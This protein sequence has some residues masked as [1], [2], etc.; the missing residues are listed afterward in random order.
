MTQFFSFDS[1]H[2]EYNGRPTLHNISFSLREGE[3]LGIIGESGSGKSTIIKSIIDI[4]GNN[5]RITGGKI[6]FNGENLLELSPQKMRK[7]CGP[8]IGMIFQD[9]RSALCPVRSIG[10]QIHD[11]FS[12]HTNT[13]RSES[14]RQAV[15]LLHKFGFK[16]GKRILNS[17]PFELSGG[18]IQR[19]GIAM[20][21]LLN[22][23]LILADEPT[24]A[25]D[26]SVQKQIL[27]EVQRLRDTYNTA[28]IFVS[29]N[30]GVIKTIAD[31][32]MVLKNGHI[33]E[34]GAT[35]DVFNNPQQDYTKELIA[36]AP[37]LR[38]N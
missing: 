30:I 22:P 37:V 11:T 13:S 21:M 6:W 34:Y 12:A 10:S 32:V 20:A 15:D 4:L 18:M 16:D 17:Y 29:H 7:I 28:V 38:R 3:I 23:S 5:A 26:V 25:L 8:K 1:V 14:D 35:Q 9:C 2:I 36:A 24:S 19:V 33:V 31:S 27:N